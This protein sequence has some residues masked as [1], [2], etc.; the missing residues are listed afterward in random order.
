M[1]S[2]RKAREEALQALYQRELSD[3]TVLPESDTETAAKPET[4]DYSGELISGVIENIEKIDALI[5]GASRNWSTDR[6]S[7]VDRSILRLAVYEITVRT[8]IPYKVA[9][10]EAVALAKKYGTEESGSFVN[11]VLDTLNPDGR[12]FE[13]A[14][15]E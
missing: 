7:V 12:A 14:S 5:N 13:S 9:I 10:N 11:G 8:D 3:D 1:K 6:M 4:T 15:S 2:R